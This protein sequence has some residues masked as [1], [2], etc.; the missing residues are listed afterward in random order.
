MSNDE[1]ICLVN[2]EGQYSIWFASK[3]IPLGWK[4]E[5]PKGSKEICLE[6][7]KNTWLD[8]RPLSLRKQMEEQEKKVNNLLT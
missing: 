5:G 4:K 6:Y 3:E 2:N 7:I 8:M 1:Y